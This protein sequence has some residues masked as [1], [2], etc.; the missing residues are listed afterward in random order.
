MAH[1]LVGLGLDVLSLLLLVG[2][3]YRRHA[4]APEMT[5]VFTMLNIG[6][7][8]AMVAIASG[9]FPV[10]VGFGLFGLLSLVRLRSTQ[11]TIKDIA[12]T[13]T[14]LVL[15]LVNAL[16]GSALWMAAVLDGVLILAVWLVDDTR[17]R[18]GTEVVRMTLK[19]AEADPDALAQMVTQHLGSEPLGVAVRSVDYVRG[20]TVV[21]VRR[22]VP[23]D[24]SWAI[25]ED[26]DD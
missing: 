11:F 7:F 25:K 17:Q 4:S 1:N 19:K 26:Q 5:M 23:A 21:D 15:A 18:L 10:G 2:W 13:F 8:A 24:N 14:A 12:Y 22:A 3:L 9:D 20:R 6:L 16:P